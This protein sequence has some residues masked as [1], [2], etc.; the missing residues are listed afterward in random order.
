E[1]YSAFLADSLWKGPSRL[2]RAPTIEEVEKLSVNDLRMYRDQQFQRSRV[3]LVVVGNI[4]KAELESKLAA[5]ESLPQGGFTWPMIEKIPPQTD[6]YLFIPKPSDFPTTYVEMRA[7][8][9]SV[10]DEDW[11]AER[12]LVE[13]V[14]KHL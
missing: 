11:W 2:N 3:V 7:P 14:D 10:R 8:S 9:A 1:G 13:L 12:I 5:L 6:Q 4:S